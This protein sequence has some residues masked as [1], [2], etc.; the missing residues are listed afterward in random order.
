L[1]K[2]EENNEEKKESKSVQSPRPTSKIAS[3]K[4]PTPKGK[5]NRKAS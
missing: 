4:D 1:D 3:N 5:G 2:D